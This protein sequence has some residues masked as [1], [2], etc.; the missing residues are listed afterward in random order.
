MPVSRVNARAV[1]AEDFKVVAF[2]RRDNQGWS[3]DSTNQTLVR[4]TSTADAL[5]RLETLAT[6]MDAAITIPGTTIV[7][8]LDAFI[9]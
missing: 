8:G 1:S 6:L 9:G 4:D 7:M 3:R 5:I 2:D